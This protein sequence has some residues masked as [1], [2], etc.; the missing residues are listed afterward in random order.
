MQ[1]ERYRL[2]CLVDDKEFT[3]CDSGDSTSRSCSLPGQPTSYPSVKIGLDLRANT[4]LIGQLLPQATFSDTT[5]TVGCPRSHPLL[6]LCCS[7]KQTASIYLVL[8][9]GYTHR[10]S[11]KHFVSLYV[12]WRSWVKERL[13]QSYNV[14]LDLRLHVRTALYSNSVRKSR[15]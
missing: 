1:L 13:V 11:S 15:N 14:E 4:C 5:K 9:T 8:N 6:L 3:A 7:I 2:A 12:N 10:C